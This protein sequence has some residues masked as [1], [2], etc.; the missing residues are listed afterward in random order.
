M[1]QLDTCEWATKNR[2]QD[3]SVFFTVSFSITRQSHTTTDTAKDRE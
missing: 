3:I 1:Y 2:T